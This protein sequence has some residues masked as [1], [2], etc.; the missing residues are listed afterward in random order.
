[1]RVR[2]PLLAPRIFTEAQARAE[3]SVPRICISKDGQNVL[4]V[5]RSWRAGADC[6]SVVLRLRWFESTH[7]HQ[8]HKPTKWS[9]FVFAVVWF[10]KNPFGSTSSRFHKCNAVK[11]LR[12]PHSRHIVPSE[13][14]HR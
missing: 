10:S 2:F 4:G 14:I 11:S 1:M 5:R 13:R 8:K 6:K 9:V 3:N 7:S 12:L